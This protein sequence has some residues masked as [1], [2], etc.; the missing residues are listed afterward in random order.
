VAARA[1]DAEAVLAAEPVRRATTLKDVARLA[2]VDPSTASRVLRGDPNQGVRLETRG[3]ILDAARML[4]YRP[5]AVAQ[6][7]RTR[8]TDTFAVI[9][10]TLD[11][12]GLIEV[13]RGIQTEAATAGKLVLLV[14]ADAIGG[15]EQSLAQREELF[16]RLVLDGRVDGLIVAFATLFGSRWLTSFR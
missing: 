9:V 10:P 8:R 3:R 14:D 5:N 1:P 11:N 16:A 6:S 12:P 13:I 7:L 4:N 15:G 2:E